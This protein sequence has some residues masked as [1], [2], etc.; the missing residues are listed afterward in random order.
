MR[1]NAEI[2]TSEPTISAPR[3]TRAPD[4]VSTASAYV[5]VAIMATRVG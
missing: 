5:A 2:D 1:T 4:G 3:A